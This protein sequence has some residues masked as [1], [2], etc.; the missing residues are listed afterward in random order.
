MVLFGIDFVLG[1]NLLSAVVCGRNLQLQ[2]SRAIA[3]IDQA[4]INDYPFVYV[5]YF[6]VVL[7]IFERRKSLLKNE[8]S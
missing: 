7:L 5:G 3:C 8:P 6:D 4:G 1:D 2:G